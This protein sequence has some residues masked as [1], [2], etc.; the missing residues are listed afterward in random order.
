MSKLTVFLMLLLYYGS[1][2]SAQ[3]VVVTRAIRA[4]NI[5]APADVSLVN[6]MTQGAISNVTE[7]IGLEA[8]V[9]LYPGRAVKPSDVGRP[10][11]FERNQ[12]VTMVYTAGL[13]SITVEG[14]IL[15]RS[16]IGD[17]ARVMNMDSRL[18]VVGRVMANGTIEVGN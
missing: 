15:D 1:V 10:A 2:A 7:V 6:E 3:T 8:R 14:R 18:T 17:A 13:L 12:I 16:G 11:I 4:N 9:N 5:I